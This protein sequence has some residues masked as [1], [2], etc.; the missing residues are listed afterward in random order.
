MNT[1]TA[2]GIFGS[3]DTRTRVRNGRNRENQIAKA[4]KEQHGLPL[5]EPTEAEDKY[6]K[7]DRWLVQGDSRTAVQ[8]KYRE[9]GDDLL[10]E[11]WD[12]W[13]GWGHEF[14]KLG[15]D[16]QGDSKLYAVLRLDRTTVVLTSADV[17]KAIVQE[18]VDHCIAGGWTHDN[19]PD[20]KTFH[21]AKAGGRC[22]LKV[23]RDPHDGRAKMVAYIP[24]NVV[25]AEHQ[26]K[27]YR[28]NLPANWQE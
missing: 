19:G 22:V 28:V 7:I 16:V 13:F 9:S 23:Q 6:R 8:I 3:I 2:P 4:L 18:M 5:V 24:A 26:A 15:R 17:L 11:V 25:I 1:T 27:T 21:F 20:S 12:K 14:N 10:V